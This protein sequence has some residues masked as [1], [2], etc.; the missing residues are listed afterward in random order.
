MT[1][2]IASKL[3]AADLRLARAAAGSPLA[4]RMATIVL[5]AMLM[6]AAPL[7][8]SA[9]EGETSEPSPQATSRVAIQVY[10]P[11]EFMR[12]GG[13]LM[14]PILVCSIATVTFGLERLISLRRRRVLAPTFVRRLIRRLDA[15]DID[16]AEAIELCKAHRSPMAAILAGALRY[17]GRPTREI[18]Q[19]IQEAGE[20]EIVRLQRNL[21]ALQGSA[22]LA[23][24]LGLLGT[25]LGMVEAF[26][27]VAAAKG[28]GRAELLADG[29]AVAL[30]T[31]VFGLV[32]AIP[33]VFL[34]NYFAGRVERLVYEMDAQA[35]EIV[36][37]ISAET[38]ATTK[39]PA[40]G[41]VSPKY[42]S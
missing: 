5:A 15:R 9:Q 21:R 22:N 12:R 35:T 17:W 29:I 25:V 3:D 23:T 37:R 11:V 36:D 2:G 8:S 26:N 18:E 10:N 13:A 40:R 19:A 24:L 7:M 14:W 41:K 28:L 30:L 1:P 39:Q 4:T 32:V 6:S 38:H 42:V 33:S 20:R 34:Y 16:R 27:Q 31:T